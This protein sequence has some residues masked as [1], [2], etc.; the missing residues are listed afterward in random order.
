[1]IRKILIATDG[2]ESALA[3]V[4]WV[5]DLCAQIESAIVTIVNVQQTTFPD[6][7]AG[8]VAPI[9]KEVFEEGG[10]RVL[11]RSVQELALSQDRVS[12]MLLFGSPAGAIVEQ[13]TQHDLVV[14]GSRGLNPMVQLVIGSVSETVARHA[15][16]PVV[17]VRS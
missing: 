11:D 3:A 10:R 2:S 5:R 15:T 7:A 17:I 14:V 8:Y 4:R 13:A 6:F 16:C 12:T 9:P 1:M